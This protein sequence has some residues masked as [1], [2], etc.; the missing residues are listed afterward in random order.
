MSVLSEAQA[1]EI[2]TH[3][4]FERQANAFS[5]PF[6]D[7]P[8]ELPVEANRYRLIWSA[9]CP[10]ATRSVI[11]INLLGLNQVISIGKASP[12]RPKIDHADWAFTL[13]D[14]DVDPVL[15]IHYLSEAYLKADPNYTGRPTVPAVVDLKSGKVV[16]N[17]YFKLT[18]YFEVEWQKFQK[19][20]APDLYP[21]DLR[22]DIDALNDIIFHDVNNGV[23]KAGFAT[24][25]AAYEDAYDHLFYRLD[26]LEERLSHHRFLFGNQLTDSD[27]RLYTT[28]ARFD[29]AYYDKFKCN[30][31]RLRDYD[32]LW[33]YARDLYRIPAFKNATE[34]D[35]IKLHY[36]VSGHLA[37]TAD[38]FQVLPKGPDQSVWLAP[39]NRNRFED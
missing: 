6:G 10:W 26:W 27:I 5:T 1:K 11:A 18:N 19:P 13:D 7:H 3:G 22:E 12:L 30:K 21:Q 16:N 29:T 37:G 34:F 25:Q 36:H 33:N 24:S 23:Y 28:L 32:N 4:K 2:T 14:G 39:N 38:Q 20:D 9:A 15:K 31:Q 35:A 8:G 17:D